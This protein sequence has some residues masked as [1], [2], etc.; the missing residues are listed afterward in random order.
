[1]AGDGPL[2]NDL[3]RMI[4]NNIENII[5]LEGYL[6]ENKLIEWYKSA[7]IYIHSTFSETQSMSI[8]QAMSFNMPVIVSNIDNIQSNLL[9]NN[10]NNFY[11]AENEINAFLDKIL[12][13]IKN[14]H[15]NSNR[16]NSRDIILEP[17]IILKCLINIIIY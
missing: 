2:F 3:N 16:N 15:H 17:L 8:L 4:K 11:V 7:D 12:Y 6:D 9:A 5:K 14:L 10:T 1:M 13:V